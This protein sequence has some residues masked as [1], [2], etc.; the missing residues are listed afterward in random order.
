VD[1]VPQPPY[2]SLRGCFWT[3]LILLFA[4]FGKVVAYPTNLPF[5]LQKWGKCIFS[6]GFPPGK[7]GEFF[8]IGHKEKM[9]HCRKKD[10]SKDTGNLLFHARKRNVFRGNFIVFGNFPQKV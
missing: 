4:D 5:S 10:F 8:H 7:V 9:P 6:T 3:A 2:F 1:F